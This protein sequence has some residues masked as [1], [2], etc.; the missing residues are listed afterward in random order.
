MTK[1]SIFAKVLLRRWIRRFWP[2]GPPQKSIKRH[3]NLTVS[4]SVAICTKTSYTYAKSN[5]QN[6]LVALAFFIF[7]F[8]EK[9][10]KSI[11]L[12]GEDGRTDRDECWSAGLPSM[13]NLISEKF[14]VRYG[15]LFHLHSNKFHAWTPLA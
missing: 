10:I 6:M 1:W 11:Y 15:T 4:I 7:P 12:L 14:S 5:F 8:Q 13:R 9:P 2:L 3:G